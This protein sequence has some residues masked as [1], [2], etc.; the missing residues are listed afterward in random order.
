M[1]L[2]I[3]Q[4][5]NQILIGMIIGSL[6]FSFGIFMLLGGLKGNLLTI[7]IILFVFNIAIFFLFR[8]IENNWD[9]RTIQKMAIANLVAIGN[10]KDSKAFL[11]IKDSTG[12]SYN[13]WEITLNYIDQDLEQHECTFYEK[14]NSTL[15]S[16]PRGT[17]F[18]THDPSKPEQKFIIQNV[19]ISHI[20]SLAPAV[21]KYE[22]NKT[23]PIKYLNVYY[24][25]GL[26]IESYKDS[27]KKAEAEKQN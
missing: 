17:V 18:I 13:L 10:I 23:F 16:I 3:Y 19:I 20:P 11:T 2:K 15:T 8:F 24:N 7:F 6:L 5:L 21:Q 9:K 27:L 4:R 22:K 25:D 26:I 1:Q 14:L 12:K